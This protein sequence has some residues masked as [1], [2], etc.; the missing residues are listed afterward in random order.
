MKRQ[1]S[2]VPHFQVLLA[3]IILVSFFMIAC[4]SED[5]V[6]RGYTLETAKMVSQVPPAIIASDQNVTVVFVSD[7][8][9]KSQVGVNLKKEV[10]TFAPSIDG[11]TVWQDQRTLIF[12]PN[13]KLPLRS[14]Y[15]GSLD[16]N[17]LFPEYKDKNL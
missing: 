9:K 8:V 14:K 5:A 7:M 2:F 15:T 17:A 1:T 13:I 11:I 4:E 3:L 10:F 6:K 16:L 12:N